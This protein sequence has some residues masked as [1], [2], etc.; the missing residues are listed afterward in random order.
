MNY[1]TRLKS[2]RIEKGLTQKQI[3]EF[4]EIPHRTYQNYE[5]G[6][7]P[8]PVNVALKLAKFYNVDIHFLFCAE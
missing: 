7:Y 1:E 6:I 8:V 3:A 2:V 5:L 4:L